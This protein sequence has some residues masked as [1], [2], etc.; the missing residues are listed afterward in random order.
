MI[1]FQLDS[2][3][4]IE[5]DGMVIM[6]ENSEVGEYLCNSVL[7]FYRFIIFLTLC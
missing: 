6:G 7:E 3:Y 2:L 5:W 1:L 4:S